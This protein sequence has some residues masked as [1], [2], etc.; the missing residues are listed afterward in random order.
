MDVLVVRGRVKCTVR[1]YGGARTGSGRGGWS[2]GDGVGGGE[3]VGKL[4]GEARGSWRGGVEVGGGGMIEVVE[5]GE[6]VF[7]GGGGGGPPSGVRLRC[8]GSSS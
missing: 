2:G 4:L 8:Q 6:R 5:E 3:G 1:R 7:G